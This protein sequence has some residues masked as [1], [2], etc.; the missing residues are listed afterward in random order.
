MFQQQAVSL[1]GNLLFGM[2]FYCCFCCC[3]PPKFICNIFSLYIERATL[4][5]E[6]VTEVIEEYSHVQTQSEDDLTMVQ[7]KF[8]A[9]KL[10]PESA[11]AQGQARFKF[12]KMVEK[13]EKKIIEN[14]RKALGQDVRKLTE[15]YAEELFRKPGSLLTSVEVQQ[16]YI[17]SG[18]SDYSAD[19]YID[20]CEVNLNWRRNDGTCNNLLYPRYGAAGTNMRRILYPDY[21]DGISHPRG[22]KQMKGL[23]GSIGSFDPPN[24][25]PRKIS[26]DIFKDEIINDTENSLMLMQW[27]QFIDHDLDLMPE[28]GHADC[29]STCTLSDN[30]ANTCSPFAIEDDDLVDSRLAEYCHEFRRSLPA[31]DTY[32]GGAAYHIKPREHFNIITHFLDASNVYNH[33]TTL[34]EKF[35]RVHNGAKLVVSTDNLPSGKFYDIVV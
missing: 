4:I 10:S 23:I 12:E 26:T 20:D 27:G 1:C 33:N 9:F 15:S 3:C 8:H 25:S 32:N 35:L 5:D 28:Y 18:C 11:Q 21:E 7:K 13:A 6:A 22:S 30:A 16:L 31:C 19:T 29:E 17:Y 14:H 24:P 2:L 34:Q